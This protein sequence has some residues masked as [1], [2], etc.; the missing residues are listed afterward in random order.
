MQV[1]FLVGRPQQVLAHFLHLVELVGH[2]AL[3]QSDGGTQFVEQEGEVL[4]RYEPRARRVILTPLPDKLVQVRGFQFGLV[5]PQTHV[6][7]LQHHGDEQVHGDHGHDYD[8]RQNE[9]VGQPTPAPVDA[10]A[11]HFAHWLVALAP[12]F[13]FH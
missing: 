9:R 3:F 11:R 2:E 5:L 8:V 1:D 6:V 12:W 10:C 4:R 13:V 7:A